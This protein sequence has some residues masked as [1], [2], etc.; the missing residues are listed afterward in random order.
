[1]SKKKKV[2]KF[3]G[4]KTH[5]YGAKKKHRG[6][7]SRGGR[8]KAGSGKRA[9]QKKPSF[10]KTWKNNKHKK[11]F[12]NK[13]KTRLKI[14]NIGQLSTLSEK[15]NTTNINLEEL[16]FHKLLG[17]GFITKAFNII[18]NSAS[19]KAIEKI[20]AVGGE[21]TVL[22]KNMVEKLSTK[23]KSN[24][25]ITETPNKNQKQTGKA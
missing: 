4:S 25:L 16:G 2:V 13:R 8:G 21:I 18:V 7:G 19:S 6:A 3:R 15:I 14:I 24:A 17:S 11:G 9:D 12:K 23:T 5:G 1:M 20:K 10:W 22:E